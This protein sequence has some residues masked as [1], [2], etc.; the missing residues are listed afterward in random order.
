VPVSQSASQKDVAEGLKGGSQ[1]EVVKHSQRSVNMNVS[2]NNVLLTTQV[3]CTFLINFS[4]FWQDKNIDSEDCVMIPEQAKV[5]QKRKKR[6][7]GKVPVR[8]SRRLMELNVSSI[9]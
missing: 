6:T 5:A 9:K 4:I 8:A 7:L 1:S 2:T 3:I